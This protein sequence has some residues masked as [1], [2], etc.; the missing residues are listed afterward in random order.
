MG[1]PHDF[2]EGLAGFYA[3]LAEIRNCLGVERCR[4]RQANN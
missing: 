2:L 1:P 4:R 3:I